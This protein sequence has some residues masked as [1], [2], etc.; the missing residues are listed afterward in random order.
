MNLT[1]A[2]ASAVVAAIT[3]PVFMAVMRRLK[4]FRH[5]PDSSKTFP[6]LN[7]EYAK[8]E[9]LALP[10][11]MVSVT[12]ITAIIWWMLT[13]IYQGQIQR[14]EPSVYVIELPPIV[15]TLPALF[16]ALFLSALPL[17]FLFLRLLGKHRYAEYVEYGNQKFQI[18]AWKLFKYL[19]NLL[20]PLCLLATMMA[21]DCYTR[22][23]ERE[24]VVN[25]FFGIGDTVYAFEQVESITRVQSLSAPEGDMMR[26]GYYVVRFNGGDSYDFYRSWNATGIERQRDIAQYVAAATG[27]DIRVTN[28]H[29]E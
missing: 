5:E 25:R 12:A 8:W 22:I 20:L 3:V 23:G 24:I 13:I 19:G 16:F 21:L 2:I 4:W 10:V 7:H 6:Q 26:R 9:L 27:L 18:N 15:W 1:P 28:R 11:V 29:P 17:H 14:L